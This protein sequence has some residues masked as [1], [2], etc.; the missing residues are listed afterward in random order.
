MT[1]TIVG[2]TIKHR[3]KIEHGPCPPVQGQAAVGVLE[4]ARTGVF[5]FY[6]S[7]YDRAEWHNLSISLS[8]VWGRS[9]LE[10]DGWTLDRG[11]WGCK[12]TAD[13]IGCPRCQGE[14]LRE[15]WGDLGQRWVGGGLRVGGVG[16]VSVCLSIGVSRPAATVCAGRPPPALLASA[17]PPALAASVQHPIDDGSPPHDERVGEVGGF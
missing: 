15:R 10:G 12:R 6:S 16:C 2:K 9:L 13:R 8:K 5:N 1:E 3:N 17:S 7:F 11:M 14:S 4:A